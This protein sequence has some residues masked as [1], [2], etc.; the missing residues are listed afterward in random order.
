MEVGGSLP[1][2]TFSELGSEL[3][4]MAPQ[5]PGMLVS[6]FVNLIQTRVN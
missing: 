3:L 6:F 4:D 5:S 1:H 2:L